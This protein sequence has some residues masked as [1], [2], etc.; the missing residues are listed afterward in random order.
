MWE[1]QPYYSRSHAE[2]ADLFDTVYV[3]LYKDLG[4]LAGAVLAGPAGL[5]DHAREWRARLGGQLHHF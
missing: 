3:S 2:I 5:I 1:A 4:G